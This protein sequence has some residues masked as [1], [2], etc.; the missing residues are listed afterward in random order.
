MEG[1]GEGRGTRS[2]FFFF[3]FFEIASWGLAFGEGVRVWVRGNDGNVGPART[4]RKAVMFFVFSKI[5][6]SGNVS[7]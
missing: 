4:A 7:I 1:E 5:L 3:F 6:L 2:R